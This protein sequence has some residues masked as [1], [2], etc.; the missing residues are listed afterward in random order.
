M[1]HE[2]EA[3]HRA[4]GSPEIIF[5][6]A[7]Q[8]L[9]RL[10][11]RE[12][13]QT[14]A[15]NVHGTAQLLEAVRAADFP[16]SRRR[17]HDRQVLRQRRPARA[18]FR[19]PIRSAATIP[20]A[21]AR[22]RRRSS[23][24]R[25]AIRFSRTAPM[26]RWPRPAPA[27]SSA[28]ATGRRTASCP[29]AIRALPA[30]QADPRAQS[31][32]HAAVAACARAARRLSAARREAGGGARRRNRRRKSRATRRPSTSVPSPDANRTVRELVEEILR[33]WPGK[34]EQVAQEKHL[35]GSAAAQ[36]RHRQG[37]SRPRLATALGFRAH[38]ER[39]PSRGI[40][41]RTEAAAMIDFTQKQ[42]ASYCSGG[43]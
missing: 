23:S 39:K 42:I 27:T 19:R 24:P 31:R 1:L 35:P 10:S 11:Y 30:G 16:C 12:P 28:A 4:T 33:H 26:S 9:V 2:L 32:F 37:R 5:H 6:L 43:L 41:K 15:T 36:P 40:A 29:T 17:G 13:V 8:P 3:R 7:A 14:F 38:C 22:R 25:I 34:W 20:T 18:A 21:R